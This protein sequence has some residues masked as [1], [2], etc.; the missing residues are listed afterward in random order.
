MILYFSGCGYQPEKAFKETSIMMTFFRSS[1]N[2]EKRFK[3]IF[4]KRRK[5]QK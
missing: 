5:N 4:R 1:K 3:K 2:P